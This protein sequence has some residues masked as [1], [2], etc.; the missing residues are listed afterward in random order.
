MLAFP[1]L[2]VASISPNYVEPENVHPASDNSPPRF[3]ASFVGR[4]H[5]N[6]I[7]RSEAAVNSAGNTIIHLFCTLE[8][9]VLPGTPSGESVSDGGFSYRHASPIQS[10][11]AP[12]QDTEHKIN[13]SGSEKVTEE[14]MRTTGYRTARHPGTQRSL[15]T[16]PNNYSR[17]VLSFKKV[18]D[19][20]RKPKSYRPPLRRRRDT[21]KDRC[22]MFWNRFNFES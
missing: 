12:E 4:R 22:Y 18:A 17:L 15:Q 2:L 8:P 9:R 10:R 14:T 19:T 3:F 1:V 11:I 21:E 7:V 13:R 5:R 6:K 16:P 20:S